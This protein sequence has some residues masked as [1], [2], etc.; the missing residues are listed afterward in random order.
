MGLGAAERDR[1]RRGKDTRPGVRRPSGA[2]R[3]VP[4]LPAAGTPP[5]NPAMNEWVMFAVVATIVG[6]LVV[7]LRMGVGDDDG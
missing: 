5:D 1:K 6:V 4:P 7:L 3:Q 2:R